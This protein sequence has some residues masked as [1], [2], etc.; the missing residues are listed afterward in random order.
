M[1]SGDIVYLPVEFLE[2]DEDTTGN[3]VRLKYVDYENNTHIFWVKK[4]V[5][6]EFSAD[7]LFCALKKLKKLSFD[8]RYQ[9]F[10]HLFDK[11]CGFFLDIFD[12]LTTDEIIKS[13]EGIREPQIGDVYIHTA[14]GKRYIIYYY[15]GA[16]YGLLDDTGV[17]SYSRTT[18]SEFFSFSG[19]TVN[20]NPILSKIKKGDK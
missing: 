9:L 16:K 19:E 8:E 4:D 12:D 14:D 5:L 20:L 1:K 3:Y 18:L 6:S 13:C 15:D 10:N 7:D 17:Y 11:K 2:E